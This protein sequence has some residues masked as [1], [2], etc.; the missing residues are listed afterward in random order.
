MATEQMTEGVGCFDDAETVAA[1]FLRTTPDNFFQIFGH[2]N[3]RQTPLTADG[4]VFNLE[5]QVER[6]GHLRCFQVSHDGIR[7]VEIKNDVFR[8]PEEEKD[9]EALCGSPIADVLVSLRHNRYIV[10]KKFGNLSSFNYT[11]EAFHG[12][13]WNSQTVKARG[14]YLDTAKGKVAAR[15]YDKFFNIGE[16]AQ[17]NMGSL[18]EKLRFPVSVYVKENGFLGIVS[19]NEYED[20]RPANRPWTAGLP[21]G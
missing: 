17:T 18:Q 2:R 11:D 20:E 16:C 9:R 4:R 7:P 5:G 8:S 21:C 14:L 19:Y 3:M 12:G 6:G 13:V 10:E 1:S 15:A